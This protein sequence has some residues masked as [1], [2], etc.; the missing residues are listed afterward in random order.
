MLNKLLKIALYITVISSFVTLTLN[1]DAENFIVARMTFSDIFG[2]ISLFLFAILLIKDKTQ[3]PVVIKSLK[4][5]LLMIFG[6]ACSIFLSLNTKSTLVEVLIILYL[7]LLSTTIIYAFKNSLVSILFPLIIYT[8]FITSFIGLYDLVARNANLPV[9][10]KMAS[11]E[12]GISG[13]RYFGQAANYIFT[14]LTILIP[15]RY[16]NYYK[17]LE[18]W[19]QKFLSITILL[20]IIFLCTT[21]RISII[22]SFAIGVVLFILLNPNKKGVMLAITS[23]GLLGVF[24][25][26]ITLYMPSLKQ[27]IKYRIESRVTNRVQGTSESDFVVANFKGAMDAFSDNPITGSGLGAF[28]NNYSKFE[29]HGTYLKVLG[30]TGIIGTVSYFIFLFYFLGLLLKGIVNN[31]KTLNKFFKYLLP[32]M[33]ANL[34]SWSYNHHLRKKEFWI[35]YAVVYIVYINTKAKDALNLNETKTY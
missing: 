28:V 17:T 10:F 32:F 31:K 25:V 8:A 19:P 24:W 7:V 4:Y 22:I 14:M 15:L 11:K 33:V 20:G 13:F 18:K 5:P 26:V 30:E 3:I 21:G 6:L 12:V 23:L 29:V 2:L 1:I 35:L 27:R 34:I 9:I 16:S